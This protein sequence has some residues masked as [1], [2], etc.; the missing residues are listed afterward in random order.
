LDFAV[1]DDRCGDAVGFLRRLRGVESRWVLRESI[2]CCK[3]NC[4][5]Y[6]G[7][8]AAKAG[9]SMMLEGSGCGRTHALF[10]LS[11]K[12]GSSVWSWKEVGQ[13]GFE[14]FPRRH[15]PDRVL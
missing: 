7:R 9:R 8:V 13:T 15:Y 14:S 3:Q 2:C 10:P 5:Q 11:L 4:E 6:E 12:Q 1:N